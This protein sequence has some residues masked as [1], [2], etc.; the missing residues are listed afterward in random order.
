VSVGLEGN[1]WRSPVGWKP[2]RSYSVQAARLWSATH[3]TTS[4]AC[5]WSAQRTGRS[6]SARATPPPDL[7]DTRLRRLIGPAPDLEWNLGAV[8]A[9]YPEVGQLARPSRVDLEHPS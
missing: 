2:I 3:K 9:C 6:I 4:Q 8:G 1:G 5:R 7:L